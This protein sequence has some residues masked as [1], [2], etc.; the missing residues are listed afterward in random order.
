[1]KLLL[2]LSLSCLLFSTCLGAST[3]PPKTTDSPTTT[4][5]L[6]TKAPTP[7]PTS[8]VTSDTT[9]AP[10]TTTLPPAEQCK[11]AN[12]SCDSCIGVGKTQ[13]VWCQST[14]ACML[15]QHVIPT[16]ECALSDARWAVCWLNY[17]ALIIAC[18]VIGGLLVLGLTVCICCCCCCK[19]NNKA[20]YAK[21]D[22]KFERKKADLKSK[23]EDKKAERKAKNDE[24]RRKYGLV[25]DDNPYTRFDDGTGN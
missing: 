18:S 7:A 25:K 12:D 6:T 23:H 24:I 14:K 13:C 21:E 9:Q 8:A 16:S 17:E 15:K 20:K 4:P 2:F 19:G 1:M 11:R 5:K 3:T 22:A 10:P